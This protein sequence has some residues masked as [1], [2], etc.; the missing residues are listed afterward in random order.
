VSGAAAV[1]TPMMDIKNTT[2]TTNYT[3]GIHVLVP[4]AGTNHSNGFSVGTAWNSKNAG[5]MGFY[6]AGDGVDTNY[7]YL[8]GHSND[9]ALKVFMG[10]NIETRVNLAVGGALSKASGSF[11]IPH[12][13]PAKSETHKLVH[14]FVESPETMLL[15][16]GEVTLV[17]GAAEL[18][19]NDVAGMT[20]GTWDLLC[21]EEMVFVT[22][23]TGWSPVRGSISGST[24][25]LECQDATST[26]TVSFLVTAN[27]HDEHIIETDWTDEEG[28]PIVEPEV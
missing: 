11:R 9:D 22:N 6:S 21:R 23:Q 18:D 7:L 25:T 24:L 27:R 10:G 26:D 13:L 5:A 4:N 20:S 16:R 17:D 19:M 15:Y 28:R 1:D 8:G 3:Q 12:P 2:A 14:S